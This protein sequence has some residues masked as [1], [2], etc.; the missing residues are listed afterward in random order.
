MLVHI[1]HTV[2]WRLQ[3]GN[4]RKGLSTVPSTEEM[5]SK[6]LRLLIF[7][8][9][10]LP[11]CLQHQFHL[12]A[13][14]GVGQGSY[15]SLMLWV[16]IS[17]KQIYCIFCLRKTSPLIPVAIS[18]DPLREERVERK[19]TGSLAVPAACRARGI[20]LSSAWVLLFLSLAFPE[21][22]TCSDLV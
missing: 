17:C 11:A 21:F 16:W 1:L 9:R 13:S 12:W 7:N 20:Y 18:S 6:C 2:I 5:H 22:G 4:S 3:Q 14:F 19:M 8:W 10:L 15:G